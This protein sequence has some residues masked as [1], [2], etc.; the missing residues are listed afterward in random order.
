MKRLTTIAAFVACCLSAA[1]NAEIT[2]AAKAVCCGN[3]QKMTKPVTE[4]RQSAP[5]LA[6]I[7]AKSIE[8]KIH[9]AGIEPC[10]CNE[11]A[12]SGACV[13]VCAGNGCDD[14]G[15]SPCKRRAR[16]SNCCAEAQ[17]CGCPSTC[18]SSC[19]A[20]SGCSDCGGCYASTDLGI[21]RLF[22]GGR[23][24]GGCGGAGLCGGCMGCCPGWTAVGEVLFLSR[25]GAEDLTLITDQNTGNEMLNVGDF[26]FDYNGAPRLFIRHENANCIGFEFGYIGLDSW[27]DVEVRGNPISP[28]LQGPGGTAFPSAAP[29]T[30]FSAAYGSEFHSAEF[31]LRKRCGECAT[32]VAGFRMV[33][34][35]DT[36][37]ATSVAPT[38]DDFF[39][40]DADNH[41]YGFQL[42]FDAELIN[43]AG[44]FHIDSIFRCGLL[45]NSADQT[46]SVPVFAGLPPGVLATN[47]SANDDHTTFLG[48]LGI[49]AVYELNDCIS[50]GSGYHLIWL[51]GLALAPDQIPATSLAGLGSATLDTG[52]GLLLHGASI[53][54]TVRF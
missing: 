20:S 4:S 50:V 51:E 13:D 22:G 54:M 41:M 7:D 32:W 29:G 1:A 49:R 9:T 17:S 43:C 28:T 3:D 33:D 40:I 21:G 35:S 45:F 23:S 12:S 31:N 8:S 25:S 2:V 36:L 18:A 38:P 39:T 48:E 16:K 11:C 27:N 46:T 34:F 19:C 15:C 26:D 44:Q 30:V 6:D 47:V 52:G 24:R 10:G 53:N 14:P 37:H 5:S 42:G